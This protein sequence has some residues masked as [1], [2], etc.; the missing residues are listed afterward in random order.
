MLLLSNFKIDYIFDYD[1]N[2]LYSKTLF[3]IIN[4]WTHTLM[5]YNFMI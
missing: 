4:A 3:Q 2:I 5:A 1:Y